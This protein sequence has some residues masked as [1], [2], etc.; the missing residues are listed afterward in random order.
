MK[1]RNHVASG[2]S[3]NVTFH[4]QFQIGNP[5]NEPGKLEIHFDDLLEGSIQRK[6]Y[7]QVQ[8]EKAERRGQGMK[9]DG[10]SKD[11]QANESD[12]QFNA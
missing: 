4:N 8:K 1:Y 9:R 12:G 5:A 11:H 2:G 10:T 7:R 6:S 3:I